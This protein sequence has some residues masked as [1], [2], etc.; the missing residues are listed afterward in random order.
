MGPGIWISTLSTPLVVK[1]SVPGERFRHSDADVQPGGVYGLGFELA[2][3]ELNAPPIQR[4]LDRLSVGA[5]WRYNGLANG[6]GFQQYTGLAV[7]RLLMEPFFEILFEGQVAKRPHN[8]DTVED[9]DATMNELPFRVCGAR[10]ISYRRCFD[11]VGELF[12]AQ[13]MFKPAE[14]AAHS[15]ASGKSYIGISEEVAQSVCRCFRS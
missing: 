10:W 4:I 8:K 6:E 2:L 7:D 15:R 12:L 1:G 13:Q 5:E 9:E 14:L 11:V 3:S